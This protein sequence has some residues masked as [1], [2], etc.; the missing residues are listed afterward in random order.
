MV[1]IFGALLYMIMFPV[2]AYL[3]EYSLLVLGL[4]VLEFVF[5]VLYIYKLRNAQEVVLFDGITCGELTDTLIFL[6]WLA[7]RRERSAY[8]YL[9]PSNMEKFINKLEQLEKNLGAQLRDILEKYELLRAFKTHK[10]KRT[11]HL[12]ASIIVVVLACIMY[13]T[14]MLNGEPHIFGD[15]PLML[16]FLVVISSVLSLFMLSLLKP[17][18]A[19]DAIT[20]EDLDKLESLLISI[21]DLVSERISRPIAIVLAGQYPKTK[22]ENRYT[23]IQPK[24][25]HNE[26]GSV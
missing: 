17:P 10:L 14:M 18:K 4:V 16:V 1:L 11:L 21:I 26:R 9:S 8:F 6:D 15:T 22:R 24:I 23:V 19:F 2:Y 7:S 12:I 25:S 5:L 13:S 3:G 20:Q